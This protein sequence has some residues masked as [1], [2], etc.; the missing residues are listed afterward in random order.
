[1]LTVLQKLFQLLSH[2]LAD[3]DQDTKANAAYGMGLLCYF[4]ENKAFIEKEYPKILQS[5]ERFLSRN[6]SDNPRILDNAA[7]CIARMIMAS[8]QSVPLAEVLPALASV[9]PLTED[10]EENDPVYK[11]LV[12]LCKPLLRPLRI[13][14]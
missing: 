8:P 4:T 6:A 11:M 7:G 12:K 10:Y 9:L 3:E 2:R 13:P 1:M 14:T 5:L